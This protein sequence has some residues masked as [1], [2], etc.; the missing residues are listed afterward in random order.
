MQYSEDQ[1]PA[2]TLGVMAEAFSAN[3]DRNSAF[4]NRVD[5]FR[6]NFQV[7]G[8]VHQHLFLHAQIGQ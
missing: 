6:P 3:I 7:E 2:V 8:D 5:L 4:L 1:V